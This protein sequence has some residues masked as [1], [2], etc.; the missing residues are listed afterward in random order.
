MS[1]PVPR[2]D[3]IEQPC[4]EDIRNDTSARTNQLQKD[5]LTACETKDAESVGASAFQRERAARELYTPLLRWETRLLALHPG[6]PDDELVAD[7]P[8][9]IFTADRSGLGLASEN[10][11][12]DYEALSYTWG[13]PL[14]TH[15]I[16]CNGVTVFITRNLNE[17]LR[18]FRRADTK[19]YLWT[20]ALCISQIDVGEKAEQISKLLQ[21][22]QRASTVVVWLGQEGESTR[23]ALA[24]MRSL[25]NRWDYLMPLSEWPLVKKLQQEDGAAIRVISGLLDLF[26]RPWFLRAWCVQELFAAA[27][28]S[29]HCGSIEI[30]WDELLYAAHEFEALRTAVAQASTETV[31]LTPISFM[32]S[33]RGR[34]GQGE[35]CRIHGTTLQCDTCFPF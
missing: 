7:L 12:V 30:G 21:I 27:T 22:F 5:M 11:V 34:Q 19:R 10:R 28:V 9:V 2:R 35:T 23:L 16:V 26:R 17:A 29:V 20:D 3:T 33:L 1:S 25:R 32:Q 13:E 14:F 24:F 6:S 8:T 31:D 4:T 15:R 18:H